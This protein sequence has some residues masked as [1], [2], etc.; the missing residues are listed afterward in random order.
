MNAEFQRGRASWMHESLFGR[1][2]YELSSIGTV[3]ATIFPAAVLCS[4]LT[5]THQGGLR[6]VEKKENVV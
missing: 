2:F 1:D 5:C 4:L 3:E 6:A